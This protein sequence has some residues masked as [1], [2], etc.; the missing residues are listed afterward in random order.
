MRVFVKVEIIKK[1]T[2]LIIHTPMEKKKK[3]VKS[4]NKYA[5][6]STLPF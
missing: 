3:L 6:V 4:F 5:F 1:T 2:L